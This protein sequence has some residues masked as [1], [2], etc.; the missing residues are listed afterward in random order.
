MLPTASKSKLQEQL[1]LTSHYLHRESGLSRNFPRESFLQCPL[2]VSSYR[3]SVYSSI[4]GGS[5]QNSPTASQGGA[6]KTNTMSTK[7]SIDGRFSGEQSKRFAV[8]PARLS[9]QRVWSLRLI[10]FP[11]VVESY[12]Q[13][14]ECR[15]YLPLHTL[16]SLGCETSSIPKGQVSLKCRHRPA[17]TYCQKTPEG[18]CGVRLDVSFPLV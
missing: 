8:P 12:T 4:S 9:S 18:R 16:W 13:M 6:P 7:V 3:Q 10:I 11:W 14:H 15:I 2:S 17:L 5:L 1:S